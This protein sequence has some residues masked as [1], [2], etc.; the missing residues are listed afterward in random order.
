MERLCAVTRY[1]APPRRGAA[2]SL[3]VIEETE[4][5]LG[6]FSEILLVILACFALAVVI[7]ALVANP[8]VLGFAIPFA[9][10]VGWMLHRIA[11]TAAIVEG[12]L[13]W[14]SLTGSRTV[15]LVELRRLRWVWWVRGS[16]YRL[17]AGH[18]RVIWFDRNRHF[19]DFLAAIETRIR[20]SLTS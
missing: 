12:N 13:E 18:H 11:L 5:R 9:L 16:W 1:G 2:S 7:G 3:S 6:W 15:P 10:V 19:D 4:Y 14:R 8:N 17:N 20:R